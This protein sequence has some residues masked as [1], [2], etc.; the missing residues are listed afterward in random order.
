MNSFGL[1]N[2]DIYHTGDKI[3]LSLPDEWDKAIKLASEVEEEVPEYVKLVRTYG[4]GTGMTIGKI[5]KV[6]DTNIWVDDLGVQRNTLKGC[7]EDVELIRSSKSEYDAQELE[8][9]KKELLEEAKKRYPVGTRYKIVHMPEVIREVTSHDLHETTFVNSSNRL[10]IN[11][12]SKHIS[13]EDSRCEA[14]S[15]YFNGQWATIVEDEFKVGD[16]VVVLDTP[17]I[18]KWGMGSKAI[19]YLFPI[20]AASNYYNKFI[21]G[22]AAAIDPTNKYG[23]NYCKTDVRKATSEEVTKYNQSKEGT[24]EIAGYKAE[25]K[26]NKIAFGCKKFSK[27]DLESIKRVQEICNNLELN[28]IFERNAILQLDYSDSSYYISLRELDTLINKL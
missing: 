11:L 14:A 12:L 3:I 21:D 27:E 7:L 23:I 13:G 4:S 1:G 18:R 26:G 22:S 25:V 17:K 28:F 19:G 24:I 9:K 5:Y 16:I 10:H 2:V 8:F 15:V 6:C 20:R